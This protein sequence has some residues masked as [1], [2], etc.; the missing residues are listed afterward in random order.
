LL[1]RET[2]KHPSCFV[3]VK[4]AIELQ[5]VEKDP[6]AGDDVGV[7]RR[8]HNVPSVIAE[9]SMVL[10]GHNIEPVRILERRTQHR[11][12]EYLLTKA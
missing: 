4:R 8:R 9:E 2:V 5:L 12:G 11:I 10:H 6:L 3:A 7:P 1:Q